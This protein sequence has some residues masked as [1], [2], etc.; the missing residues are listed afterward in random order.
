MLRFVVAMLA[1]AAWVFIK[2]VNLSATLLVITSLFGVSATIDKAR[3]HP[4]D[5]GL[6]MWSIQVI[7]AS[8]SIIAITDFNYAT[9]VKTVANLLV[10]MTVAIVIVLS[11]KAKIGG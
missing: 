7:S 9:L 8:L 5:E 1:L 10:N 2:D 11:R 3:T 6:L 4:Y